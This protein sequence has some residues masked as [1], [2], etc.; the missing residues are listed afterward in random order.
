MLTA[1]NKIY[2]FIFTGVHFILASGCMTLPS[3]EKSQID[4]LPELKNKYQALI[5]SEDFSSAEEILRQTKIVVTA[6][7]KLAGGKGI[8]FREEA[9]VIALSANISFRQGNIEQAIKKWQE[10]F[11]VQFDGTKAQ[12]EIDEQNA[13]I[14]DAIANGASQSAAKSSAQKRNQKTY[15]YT[16]Y[17]TQVPK[18]EMM[19]IGTPDGTV[20]RFP[21]QAEAFP[22][23]GVMKLFNKQNGT[24][25]TATMVSSRVAISAAHCA[26]KVKEETNPSNLF[27]RHLGIIENPNPEIKIE[28]FITHLGENKSWNG[29]GRNDWVILVTANQ[30]LIE[31]GFL[32]IAEQITPNQKNG[33]GRLMLAGYSSDLKSG[34][35][36]T[37]H[38]GCTLKNGPNPQFGILYTN[39]ENASGSSGAAVIS[40]TQPYKIIAVHT[41]KLISPKDEYSSV[42]TSIEAFRSL[43]ISVI[44]RYR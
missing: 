8:L 9:K 20:L 43:L 10:S 5:A 18:P 25:C 31:D 4:K 41:A 44:E 13:R 26:V 28:R 21:I 19:K 34:H 38:Y 30:L 15:T 42:E 37:L 22:F 23:S 40:A 27:L 39:C 2:I 32:G 3:P 6:D 35:Y 17:N 24:S 7:G 1:R 14:S 12:N 29:E 16:I 33:N 36:L 11:Q